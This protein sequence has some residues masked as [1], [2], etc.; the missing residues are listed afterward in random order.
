M[1]NLKEINGYVKPT[2]DELPTIV[3]DLVRKTTIGKH[4][5]FTNL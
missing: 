5:T 3:A 2:L 1:D 4:K